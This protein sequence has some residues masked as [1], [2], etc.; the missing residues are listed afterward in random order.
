MNSSIKLNISRGKTCEWGRCIMRKIIL[1]LLMLLVG[2]CAF[3]YNKEDYNVREVVSYTYVDYDCQKYSLAVQLYS[4]FSYARFFF[5]LKGSMSEEDLI[6]E[7]K[8]QAEYITR[9]LGFYKYSIY[10]EKTVYNGSKL[11]GY[12]YVVYFD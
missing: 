12:N 4:D 9:L 11:S 3:S 8:H 1:S 5:T 7:G 10:Q 6:V 2:A